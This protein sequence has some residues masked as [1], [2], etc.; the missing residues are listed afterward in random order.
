MKN[1]KKILAVVLAVVLMAAMSVT[2]FADESMTGE[3]G[4]IGEFTNP[5]TPVGQD[6]AVILYKEITAYNK[7]ASTVNAPAIEYTYTIAPGTAGK[8]VKD[9]GTAALHASEQPAVV[10][11]KAGLAGATISGSVDGGTTYV[12]GKLAFTNAVQLTTADNGAANKFPLK[13]DFSGVT[14]TGAG[15]YR[16]VISET[17]TAAAKTAA[18]ITDGGIAETLYLDVYVMDGATAG[19]YE[20]YGYVCF[21]ADNNIDGTSTE[22][23]NAAEKTEGFVTGDTD[24]DGTLETTEMADKYYTFNLTIS[25][26]LNG[27]QAHNSNQFPFNVDFTNAS[28]TANILLKQETVAG[29]GITANLP[30][31]AAVSSLDVSG[32]NLKLA[33]GA[34]VKYIGIPVGVSAATTVAVYETNNVSDTIYKYTYAIDGGAASTAADINPNANSATATLNT[35]VADTD[36]EVSHTIAFTNTLET[37]SPTGV[38]L[39]IAP[40]AI[41]LLA[42]VALFVIVRRRKV[43]D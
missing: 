14:W 6:D 34:S 30:A 36:D 21:K 11:T 24:G 29:D 17:T 5:D 2:M 25:K 15:V 10:L 20:I 35:I 22:S 4:V 38:I 1:L 8:T 19:T 39:R 12:A 27:D 23:L 32:T 28:V 7:D 33:N 26:T 3:G 31:A 13:I 16:Y 9:A 42:G 40:F 41:I 37:I 18:G 43:E